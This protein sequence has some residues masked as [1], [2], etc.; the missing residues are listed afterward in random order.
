MSTEKDT[1]D[2]SLERLIA[3]ARDEFKKYLSEPPG[4]YKD[5]SAAK[6]K[7][8]KRFLDELGN[9]NS[10]KS[11]QTLVNSYRKYNTTLVAVANAGLTLFT[12]QDDIDDWFKNMRLLSN[13]KIDTGDNL[14][15]KVFNSSHG[16]FRAKNGKVGDIFNHL[17]ERIDRQ[18]K[19]TTD[20]KRIELAEA[21][22]TDQQHRM[23]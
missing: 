1:K 8:V 17:S 20:E 7:L 9:V 5:L 14:Y 16:F 10:L 11:F 6:H 2:D 12:T 23:T 22:A 3:D 13:A 18:L 21:H 4:F 19:G 15:N